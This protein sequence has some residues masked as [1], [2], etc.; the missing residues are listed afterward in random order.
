MRASFWV[1]IVLLLH[2]DT[3]DVKKTGKVTHDELLAALLFYYTN[4]D[5]EDNP[6]NFMKGPLVD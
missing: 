4:I 5:D 6:L 1:S 2:F 3:M